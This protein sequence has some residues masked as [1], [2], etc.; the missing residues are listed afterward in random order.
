MQEN[1]LRNTKNCMVN[2]VLV[3][4]INENQLYIEYSDG[5]KGTLDLT[6]VKSRTEHQIPNSFAG[7]AK[8]K[9]DESTGDFVWE[10]GANICKNAS[11]RILEL[12]R[13][14]KSIKLDI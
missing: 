13:L 10:N 2:P 1:Y 14:A 8:V 12:K 9:I 6:K 11:Y 3:K 4:A 5:L 7:F